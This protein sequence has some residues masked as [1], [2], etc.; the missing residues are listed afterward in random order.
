MIF[1]ID[2]DNNIAVLDA[3]PPEDSPA[4]DG[5][6]AFDS[7][8]AFT[9]AAL[10]WPMARLVAIWEKLAPRVGLKPVSKFENRQ[11]AIVRIWRA[12]E[13]L[14]SQPAPGVLEAY[15]PQGAQAEVAAPSM[16]A[17]ASKPKARKAK[18]GK[19]A[20]AAKPA[21]AAGEAKAPREGT[22]KAK[23]IA[24]LERKG[25]ATLQEIMDATGWQAHTCR[26]FI[27]TLPKKTDLKI[28]SSRRESDKARVYKVER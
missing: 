11:V 28:T 2:S 22:A 23:V 15:G 5:T 18:D 17:A 16:I 7:S 24:L 19:S 3:A 27:S 9:C 4:T 26:A 6:L 20:K 1:R 12:I 13:K 25:G 14:A 21:K 8:K 10:E